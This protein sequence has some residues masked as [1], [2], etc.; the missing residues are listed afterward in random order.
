MAVEA[1][2]VRIRGLRKHYGD[3]I[4]LDGLDLDA[5]PGEIFG[6]AGPNGAGKSTMVKILAG[7]VE[8]DAGEIL[9]DGEPWSAGV[10]SDRVAVVHQEPQLFPNLTVAENILVG[11][12]RGRW[13]W[14]K[15]DPAWDQILDELG[16][17]D[18]LRDLPLGGAR[19]RVPAAHRDHARARAGRPCRAVRRAELGAH[20]GRVGGV[21]PA[22][23]PARRRRPR[24]HARS[25]TA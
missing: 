10:G 2:G 8:R 16:I 5:R 12:E 20:A 6:V 19:T 9:V 17:F 15:I 14:P 25:R 22:D 13:R 18:E 7:E 11:R 24:R 23:A 21:L 4:A 3:T 1:S